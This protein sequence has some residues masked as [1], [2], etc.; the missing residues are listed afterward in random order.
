MMCQNSKVRDKS[1]GNITVIR[2]RGVGR[3]P[4]SK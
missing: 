3:I 1:F 4:S 2:A